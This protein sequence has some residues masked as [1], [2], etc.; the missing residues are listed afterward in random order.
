MCVVFRAFTNGSDSTVNKHDWVRGMS[1]ILRGGLDEQIDCKTAALCAKPLD[2][3]VCVCVCLCVS[4]CLYVCV[5]MSVCVCVCVSVSV[6]LYVC[7]CVCVC[8]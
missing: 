3:C 1:T 2:L 6:C 4:V 7:V 8:V 5:D